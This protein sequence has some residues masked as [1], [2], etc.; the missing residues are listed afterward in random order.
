MGEIELDAERQIMNRFLAELIKAQPRATYGEMMIRK[1]LEQGAVD[2]LLISESMR[3][4]SV[5]IECNGCGHTWTAS[6]SRT[7]ELPDCP[8]CGVSNDSHNELSNTSLIDVLSEM[9]NVNLFCCEWIMID[10]HVPRRK[11][12]DESRL[13]D[14]WS[15]TN[16]DDG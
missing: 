5:E 2:T 16:N 6:L 11:G 9:T 14:V 13:T 8:S 15:T 12:A 10:F 1:A 7:E 4:N 3:K